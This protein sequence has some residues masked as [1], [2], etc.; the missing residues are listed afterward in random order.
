MILL[1]FLVTACSQQPTPTSP[2]VTAAN[3][4]NPASE[5]CMAAGGK[6]S[7]ENRAG[8][9]Q[10]GI[11]LFEDNRQCEEWAMLRGD[12]PVGGVKIT[13]YVTDAGRYCAISGGTY[14]ITGSS[15]TSDEQGTCTLND[16]TQCDAWDFYNATCAPRAAAPDAATIQPLVVEVCNGQ[17][18]AMAHFLDM[19]EVTQSEAPLGDPVTGHSGTGCMATVTGNG[20]KFKSPDA[21]LKL[22]DGM[23]KDE[24]WLEDPKLAAGGP[25]GIGA[26]YR[27]GDQI[28]LASAGWI[29]DSSANCPKDQPISTCPMKPEQQLYTVTINC[30]VET[31]AE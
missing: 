13:G 16:G 7:I 6:W 14:A 11:C 23:L 22:L 2:S 26:G 24:G 19:L 27:K 29:P 12:C 4:A 18:Q 9:G 25:T 31:P 1:A 10:F 17:A 5:N 21:T 15:G 8:G 28:C 3:L 30:G 20:A